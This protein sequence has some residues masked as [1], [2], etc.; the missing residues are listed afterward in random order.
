MF[1]LQLFNKVSEVEKK[2]GKSLPSILSKVPFGNVVTAFK[3][4]PVND[5]IKMVSSV[6]LDKLVEGLCIITPKEIESVSPDKLLIVL[7][8][9]NMETVRSLQEKYSDE[10]II[11]VLSELSKEELMALLVE[12][13]FCAICAVVDGICGI[14]EG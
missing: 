5:L 6:S 11:K 8:N 1:D 13:N 12:D 4:V 2:T 10:D 9:G 7:V 3:V 14:V